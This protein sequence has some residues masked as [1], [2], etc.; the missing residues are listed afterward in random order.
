[1][2][3]N[4]NTS[5]KSVSGH[6]KAYIKGNRAAEADRKILEIKGEVGVR[7]GPTL[8]GGAK[9]MIDIHR[10]DINLPANIK[11]PNKGLPRENVLTNEHWDKVIYPTKLVEAGLQ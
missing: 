9:P 11:S 3:K 4:K 2:L 7:A 10:I 8:P 5:K 1:M 6:S